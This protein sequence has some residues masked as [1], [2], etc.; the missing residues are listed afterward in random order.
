MLLPYENLIIRKEMKQV[1]QEKAHTN[2]MNLV[3]GQKTKN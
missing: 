1:F 3:G 2:T